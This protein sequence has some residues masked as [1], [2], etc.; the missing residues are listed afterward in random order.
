MP[1][2]GSL[3]CIESQIRVLNEGEEKDFDQNTRIE[4]YSKPDEDVKNK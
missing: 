4:N 2:M 1:P 3:P